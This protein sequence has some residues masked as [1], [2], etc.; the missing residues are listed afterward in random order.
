MDLLQ[1]IG[2]IVSTAAL[3]LGVVK[4]VMKI[5][6]DKPNVK[7]TTSFGFL[8]YNDGHLSEPM[9]F[10]EAANLGTRLV[11]LSVAMIR[12]P[13]SSHIV[14]PQS[15]FSVGFPYELHQGKNCKLWIPTKDLAQA[16][17]G[18]GYSKQVKLTG[19]FHDQTGSTFTSKS[20]K[21]DVEQI[22]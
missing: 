20:F 9:V 15:Q 17:K 3:T 2:T 16:V 10:L 5:Q 19:V 13:D 14:F 4:F 1:L 8:T 11:T 7:A 12:M 21:F 6:E 18:R 22:T